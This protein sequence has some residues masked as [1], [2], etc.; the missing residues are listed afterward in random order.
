[1]PK[2]PILLLAAICGLGTYPVAA[3]PPPLPEVLTASL[4]GG[5]FMYFP[6]SGRTQICG[7]PN[8]AATICETAR[9]FTDAGGMHRTETRMVDGPDLLYPPDLKPVYLDVALQPDNQNG[10]FVVSYRVVGP[11]SQWSPSWRNELVL[12]YCAPSLQPATSGNTRPLVC[13]E[14]SYPFLA[15]GDPLAEPDAIQDALRDLGPISTA[16]TRWGIGL[17]IPKGR[18]LFTIAASGYPEDWDRADVARR[19]D[20]FDPR[21]A[22]AAERSTSAMRWHLQDTNG[23]EAL[24]L[25]REGRAAGH[26][27]T[28]VSQ[29]L[30]PASPD[31]SG[32]AGRLSARWVP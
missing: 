29:A 4:D 22:P 21:S 2:T 15:L 16:A 8:Q 28:L 19:P 5:T 3:E 31:I 13:T 7:R 23:G 9:V 26:S 20:V 10:M 24:R 30:I 11:T 27:R 18:E 6:R 25:V 17:F 32:G 1:M 14:R 12:A